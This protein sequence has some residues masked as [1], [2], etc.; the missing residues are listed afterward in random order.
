LALSL[1]EAISLAGLVPLDLAMA[2]L[3]AYL[4]ES[5]AAKAA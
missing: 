1:A 3:G 2:E 4:G 5:R